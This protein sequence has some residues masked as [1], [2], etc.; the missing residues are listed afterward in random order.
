M[1]T[2]IKKTETKNE[3]KTDTGLLNYACTIFIAGTT[4]LH[5][6]SLKD[7]I[8]DPIVATPWG[9]TNTDSSGVNT[10]ITFSMPSVVS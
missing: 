6:P 7:E 10:R 4:T 3:T 8:Y 5:F 2:W 9:A 1:D